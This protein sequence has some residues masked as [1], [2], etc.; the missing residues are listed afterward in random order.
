M[1]KFFCIDLRD[2]NFSVSV[3]FF[4]PRK[5]ALIGRERCYAGYGSWSSTELR[6]WK[7]SSS[8]FSIPHIFRTRR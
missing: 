8:T 1:A 3:N 6:F 4:K 7:P 2:P 5:L